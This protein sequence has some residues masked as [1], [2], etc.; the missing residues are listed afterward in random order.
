VTKPRPAGGGGPERFFEKFRAAAARLPAGLIR[1]LPPASA[2]DLARAEAA[3]GRPIPEAYATFLRSFDGADLFHESIVLAGV[4]GAAPRALVELDQ[5]H[6]DELVFAESQAGERYGL[7]AR[8]RV[9]R[10]DEGAEERAV[11]GSSFA[12]W[13]D[14]TVAREQL[15]YGP[16][17]EYA[18]DLYDPSGEELLPRVALR[19]A[20]RAL[21]ADPDAPDAEHARGLALVRL[22][23]RAAAL[24][25]FERATALDPDNPWPWFDLGRTALDLGQAADAL[26]AFRRAA[27]R[28]TGP[29]GARLLAWAA[30]A[31]GAAGDADAAVALRAEALAR[32]ASL[33]E[34]LE[35]SAR[36][37]LAEDDAAGGR[38]ALALLAAIEPGAERAAGLPRLPVLKAQADAR[39]VDARAEVP[40]RGPASRTPP[41]ARPRRRGPGGPPRSGGSRRG[42]RR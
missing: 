31:A 2:A 23:E 26:G 24:G 33:P 25:A 3:L 21:R 5:D 28:E 12:R 17:G 13:L 15:L 18:A 39:A 10:H 30:R 6:P 22:G 27:G 20:E 34:A 42:S 32:D 11:A 7:D 1:V 9:I 35:R 40:V 36:E 8:G 4:G 38:E 41:P 14:A 16:D 37:A 19:Q 29:G